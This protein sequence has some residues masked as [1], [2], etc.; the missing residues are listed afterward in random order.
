MKKKKETYNVVK[1]EAVLI[2]LS[3]M[4]EENKKMKHLDIW[5]GNYNSRYLYIAK[6]SLMYDDDRTTCTDVQTLKSYRIY[7]PQICKK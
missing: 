1:N 2:L 5:V 3:Y 6:L 7:C 4:S